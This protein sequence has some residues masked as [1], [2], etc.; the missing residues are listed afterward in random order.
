MHLNKN[1]PNERNVAA[2]WDLPVLLG[3][4]KRVRCRLFL[5][6]FA[7]SVTDSLSRG[8]SRL[9]CAKMAE[10]IKMLFGVNTH[11]SLD[12]VLWVLIPHKNGRV[13]HF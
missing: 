5:P 1:V 4:I 2:E 11:G 12:I 7:V 9:R 13:A 10:Q 8:S 6:M 3:C